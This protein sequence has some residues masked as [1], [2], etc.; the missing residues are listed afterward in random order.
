M[1]RTVYV[2]KIIQVDS[3]D[4]LVNPDI[5]IRPVS[6]IKPVFVS[7]L[8]PLLKEG[9]QVRIRGPLEFDPI[10]LLLKGAPKIPRNPTIPRLIG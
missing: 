4:N 8:R 5:H 9:A 7:L 6:L 2:G 1:K 10:K 3:L